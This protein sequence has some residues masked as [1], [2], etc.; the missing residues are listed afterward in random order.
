MAQPVSPA[1]A[2]SGGGYQQ[3]PTA[4]PV[5]SS[6]GSA[7]GPAPVAANRVPVDEVIDKVAVMGFGR[8]QV[9]AVVRRLTENGTSV[10]FNVVLDKLM[11]GDSSGRNEVQQPVQQPAKGWY[12]R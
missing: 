9:R 4:R 1:P 3:L 8:D 2:V 7:G 10:D 6:M 11:N 5:Q 12:G